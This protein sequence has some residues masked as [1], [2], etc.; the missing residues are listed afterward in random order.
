MD[1]YNKNEEMAE[2]LQVECAEAEAIAENDEEH[3]EAGLPS[4]PIEVFINL[5]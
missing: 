5:E 3:I 1:G 4:N 2:L